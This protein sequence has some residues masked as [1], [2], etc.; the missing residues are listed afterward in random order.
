MW[1]AFVT[2]PMGRGRPPTHLRRRAG[3]GLG[4]IDKSDPPHPNPLPAGR[5][6]LSTLLH[7][8]LIHAGKCIGMPRF[9]VVPAIEVGHRPT[10]VGEQCPVF[11]QSI[12]VE[13]KAE[14]SQFVFS[15]ESLDRRNRRALLLHVKQEIAALAHAEVV[16]KSRETAQ[17]RFKQLLPVATD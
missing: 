14:K 16:V 10:I 12:T 4:L 15:E 9:N 2:S 1:F 7:P 5:G 11:L 6:S 3:E 17:R 13:S 8:E